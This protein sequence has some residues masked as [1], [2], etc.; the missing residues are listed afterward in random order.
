MSGAGGTA[1][2]E[3]HGWYGRQPAPAML[4]ALSALL[5]EGVSRLAVV[6]TRSR[7]DFEQLP[8]VFA[9]W[10]PRSK[11]E[12]LFLRHRTRRS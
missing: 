5:R 6:L 7:G 3:D 2:M 8:Q 10:S 9:D 11:P 1:A 12:V 4:P